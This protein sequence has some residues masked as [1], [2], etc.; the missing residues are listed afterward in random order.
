MTVD[1]SPAEHNSAVVQQLNRLPE[2]HSFSLA[3]RRNN[4]PLNRCSYSGRFAPSPTGPL[5]FGSLITAVASYCDAKAHQGKW[6]VRVEDTDIPRIYPG[7]EEHILTSLEAFQFESDAEIIFQKNRLDIY[8]SVLDQLKKEGLIYA[9]QCTRK[10]LGSNAIYAGTCRDLN[11]DFQGQA[12]RVKVQDQ[13]ICFDDRLQGHHCSN[14]QHDLGDF[15]LKRRD[16]IINY[17]L[18]VVVD[19]YLQGITHVV[20]GADLLDNTE[21]QIWLGQLLGY[22]QLSYMHL[23]LAMNDQGQKLSKQNLAQALD[24]SKAPELLQ[25]AILALGQPNVDLDQP[26][27]MLKQAVAQWNVD[28]IPHVQELSGTYL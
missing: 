17:Q 26:R 28:L 25:K 20:R 2:K 23:P 13:Q 24:L 7:S 10:M 6:L 18:A 22:P 27:L 1:N 14:L 19:D 9:C 12:I 16:G 11:L 4:V 15:V 8:E 21:R 5:H 3:Q